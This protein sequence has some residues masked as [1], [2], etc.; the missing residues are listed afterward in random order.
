M[1]LPCLE[2]LSFLLPTGESWISL[3]LNLRH[4]RG[5]WPRLSFPASSPGMTL[6]FCPDTRF[7][8]HNGVP[9]HKC[10]DSLPAARMACWSRVF[11]LPIRLFQGQ[12]REPE[13][14]GCYYYW[15]GLLLWIYHLLTRSMYMSYSGD[16]GWVKETWSIEVQHLS[17]ES[18]PQQS[19]SY[20]FQTRGIS[21]TDY[22]NTCPTPH[23]VSPIYSV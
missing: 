9:A 12:S 4:L 16:L 7:L 10:L 5:R 11:Q 23:Y 21:Q 20:L 18:K 17:L 19:L 8:I 2:N 22:V 15:A 1:F 13:A 3:L 14:K 6:P